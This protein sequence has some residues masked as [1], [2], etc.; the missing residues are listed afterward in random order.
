[1]KK[2]KSYVLIIAMLSAT[3]QARCL[4]S[5]T[6]SLVYQVVRVG[7]LTSFVSI[8]DTIQFSHVSKKEDSIL[9]GKIQLTRDS[10]VYISMLFYPSFYYIDP[11]GQ[12]SQVVSFGDLPYGVVTFHDVSNAVREANNLAKDELDCLVSINGTMGVPDTDLDEKAFN[13]LKSKKKDPL[14]EVI[15]IDKNN[16]DVFCIGKVI[17]SS[18]K[19]PTRYVLRFNDTKSK[20]LEQF[21]KITLLMIAWIYCV[22]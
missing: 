21:L 9:F 6:D 10:S 19:G 18:T 7:N 13:K 17:Q 8:Q 2:T 16:K 5:P 12:S 11:T 22:E 15:F 4:Q 3:I 1:M 20:D 14:Q